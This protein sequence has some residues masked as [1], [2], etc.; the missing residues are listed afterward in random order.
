MECS[1]PTLNEL[2]ALLSSFWS[3]VSGLFFDFLKGIPRLVFIP[4]RLTPVFR[5]IDPYVDK[6]GMS[7]ALR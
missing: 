2:M 6:Y 5:S 3:L 7:W 4:E 1:T